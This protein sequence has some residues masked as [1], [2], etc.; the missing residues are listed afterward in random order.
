MEGL[1]LLLLRREGFG[2][3]ERITNCQVRLRREH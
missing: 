2:S 1:L 3:N